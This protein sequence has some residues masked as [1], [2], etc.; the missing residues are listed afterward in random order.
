MFHHVHKVVIG[1]IIAEMPLAACGDSILYACTVHFFEHE[2]FRRL[3]YRFRR[4][5]AKFSRKLAVAFSIELLEKTLVGGA[6][7]GINN[8]IFLLYMFSFIFL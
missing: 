7:S 5:H 8:H 2:L 6:K 3:L 4:G 1:N